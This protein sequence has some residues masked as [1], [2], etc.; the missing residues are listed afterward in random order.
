[1]KTASRMEA[2]QPSATIGMKVKAD[3]LK[4]QGK[5]V[6]S[7]AVGEPDFP[8]PDNVVEA[9]KTALDAGETKYTAASGT[10]ELKQAI[11]DATERDLGLS[12]EPANVLVSNGAKHSL[13]NIAQVMYDPGDEVICFSPY[14]VTYPVQAEFAG[15]KP[16]A[17]ETRGEDD[18]QPDLAEVRAA[19]T[20]RTVAIMINSPCNPTGA[21]YAPEIIE[22][23][24]DIALGYDLTIISDEI[25]KH[26]LYDNAAHLSPATL[27]DGVR[28]R[29]LIV[30]GVAKTYAMTGWRIGWLLG[31][32]AWVKRAGALQGQ[33]TSCPNT[34]AQAATIEALAG[35]QDSVGEMVEQFAARRDFVMERLE[36]VPGVTCATPK[37]AF[38]AFPNI[39]AHYGRELGGG[40]IEGSLDMAEYL[41]EE[42]LIS[43]VPGQAFG[44][45]DYIR[46]SF[47]T[48][49]EELDEG[50]KRFKDALA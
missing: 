42:A 9:A 6:L 11:C 29:T 23:I 10:T 5:D 3:Q 20:D 13:M 35:P 33:A 27:G 14:W 39:S 49:M 19:V 2:I 37:G 25:Y 47:A 4:Q 38:Y 8:T 21:V 17:I 50:L 30:D 32:A 16:I 18:F 15:A 41:L 26:I 34:I 48:S 12:Y 28:A 22:G 43:L 45:D 46:I 36:E 44:A 40:K 31:D 7:F 1:M 24:A